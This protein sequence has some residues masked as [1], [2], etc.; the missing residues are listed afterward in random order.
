MSVEVQMKSEN[1]KLD[2][3]KLNNYLDKKDTFKQICLNDCINGDLI[4]FF[5]E[6]NKKISNNSFGIKELKSIILDMFDDS[7]DDISYSIKGKE[8]VIIIKD[9]KITIK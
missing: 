8:L 6:I 4:D 1:K 7:L 3:T 2:L 5:S 9:N